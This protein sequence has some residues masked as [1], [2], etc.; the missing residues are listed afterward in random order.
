MTVSKHMPDFMSCDFDDSVQNP[1]FIIFSCFV[2]FIGPLWQES[3]K[4]L[5]TTE[6]WDTIPKTEVAEILGEQVDISERYDPDGIRQA[7]LNWSN[8]L[9]QDVN[10]VVLCFAKHINLCVNLLICF[11]CAF[12]DL[13]KD[14]YLAWHVESFQPSFQLAHVLVC[15]CWVVGVDDWLDVESASCWWYHF[16]SELVV[17]VA[18]VV[19]AVEP[20]ATVR[21]SQW[22][23]VLVDIGQCL[24]SCLTFTG[25][26]TECLCSSLVIWWNKSWS[27]CFVS[28]FAVVI[29]SALHVVV[30]FLRVCWSFYY[31]FTLIIIKIYLNNKHIKAIYAYYN[32][33]YN[34]IWLFNYIY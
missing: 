34:R 2:L 11:Q 31:Y 6:C 22:L 24:L 15:D 16:A 19:I 8:D 10:C 27:G 17:C 13:W 4:T 33:V 18:T 29:I 30:L 25:H 26:I 3:V 28:F 21:L 14:C 5:H 1:T 12:V 7:V 32:V 23:P 20:V 9:L